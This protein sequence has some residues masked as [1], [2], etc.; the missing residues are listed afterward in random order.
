VTSAEP[1][2]VGEVL[3][4][5]GEALVNTAHDNTGRANDLI[6]RAFETNKRL[7]IAARIAI[8]AATLALLL[9][10]IFAILSILGM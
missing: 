10:C 6:R 4:K 3:K 1:Q 5:S 8:F 2:T 7:S 9:I